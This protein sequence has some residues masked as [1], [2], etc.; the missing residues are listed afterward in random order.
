MLSLIENIRNI[1]TEL[2]HET[3]SAFASSVIEPSI[4][5]VLYVKAPFDGCN[6]VGVYHGE[7]QIVH[8]DTNVKAV[9]KVSVE[10]FVGAEE[11]AKLL[12]G[13]IDGFPVG[14]SKLA[15]KASSYLNQESEQFSSSVAFITACIDS[16]TTS[17]GEFKQFILMCEAILHVNEWGVW[18]APFYAVNWADKNKEEFNSKDIQH[19]TKLLDRANDFMEI[20]TLWARQKRMATTGVN[21]SGFWATVSQELEYISDDYAAERELQ[22]EYGYLAEDYADD[23]FDSTEAYIEKLT[24]FLKIK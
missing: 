10:K 16:D 23:L 11:G 7:G 3:H 15:A 5:A 18:E 1:A 14:Y 17:S 12:V 4:G 8:F 22:R 2:V 21:A 9:K 20:S 24:E 13:L 6:R 19:L